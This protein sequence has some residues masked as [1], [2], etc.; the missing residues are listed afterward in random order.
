MEIPSKTSDWINR[1]KIRQP[2][3]FA[4][5]HVFLSKMEKY[6]HFYFCGILTAI[7]LIEPDFC[8]CAV[9]C[10]VDC[11]SLF[12]LSE[13]PE[14]NL[15]ETALAVLESIYHTRDLEEI[16]K[17]RAVLKATLALTKEFGNK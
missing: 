8:F 1:V 4:I 7:L 14:L 11:E 10:A 15:K 12:Q 9:K 17:I 6:D 16:L 3:L 13:V 2:K 5:A